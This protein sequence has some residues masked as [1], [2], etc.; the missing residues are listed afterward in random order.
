MDIGR[1]CYK[2]TGRNAAEKVVIVETH[3][4]GQ[5]SIMG[6]QTKKQAC[7]IFHLWPTEQVVKVSK[8]ADAKEVMNILKKK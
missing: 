8:T 6:T 5:V 4:N 1:V 7:N 2:I 3:T